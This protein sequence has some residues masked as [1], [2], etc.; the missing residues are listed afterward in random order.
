M[1]RI[2]RFVLQAF[3]A[4]LVLFVAVACNTTVE[5]APEPLTV[6]LQLKDPAG[7]SAPHYAKVKGLVTEV[8]TGNK[9]QLPETPSDA[10][11]FIVKVQPGKIIVVLTAEVRYTTEGLEVRKVV[12]VNQTLDVTAT[13]TFDLQAVLDKYAPKGFVIEEV[14]YNPPLTP[15]GKNG[16]TGEQYIKIT[17]NSDEVLYADSLAIVESHDNTSNKKEYTTNFMQQYT[18]AKAVY[19]IPGN[20]KTHP[21]E[22]GKSVII[23]NNAQNHS[24]NNTNSVDLSGANFEV[25]DQSP[26]PKYQDPDNVEVPNLDKYYASSKTFQVFNQQGNTALLLIKMPKSKADYLAQN[27]VTVEFNIT[28]PKTGEVIKK[29]SEQYMIPHSW[30]LDGVNLGIKDAVQWLFLPETIDA[31]FTGWQ[32]TRRDETSKGL[33][34]RRKTIQEGER[35]YLQDTNNSANDFERR[36]SPSLKK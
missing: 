11:T 17:N 25:Y 23:A 28:A 22:P 18:L 32:D 36:V 20:G 10:N 2:Q 34:V 21:V 31:G 13:G 15:E 30:V 3:C 8:Q 16:S 24:Q 5:P 1:L 12:K 33:A 6:T 26:N 7:I 14:Y 4:L 29:N 19:M 35:T 27:K 9:I